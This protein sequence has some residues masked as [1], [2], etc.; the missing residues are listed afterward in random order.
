MPRPTILTSLHGRK[1]GLSEKNQPIFNDSDNKLGSNAVGNVYGVTRVELTVAEMRAGFA[2]PVEL[3]AAPGAG[4]ALLVDK[5]IISLPAGTAFTGIASG[6]DIQIEYGALNVNVVTDVETTGFLD[7]ATKEMRVTRFADP[8]LSFD[9]EAAGNDNIE[10]TLLI[11]DITAGRAC[12]F[13]I[14]FEVIDLAA[15]TI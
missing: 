15:F 12:L 6:E 10:Y 3:V 9:L 14:Y 5:V 4:F 8:T 13:D 2:T 11:G 1:F 7:Q